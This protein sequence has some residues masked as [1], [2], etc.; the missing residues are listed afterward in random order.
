MEE[1]HLKHVK[2]V[3]ASLLHSPSR[4]NEDVAGP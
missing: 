2:E 3:P 4:Q 1:Y